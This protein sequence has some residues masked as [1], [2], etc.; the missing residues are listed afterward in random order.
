MEVIDNKVSSVLVGHNIRVVKHR[1]LSYPTIQ[2]KIFITAMLYR[3]LVS[4]TDLLHS[5]IDYLQSLCEFHKSYY[6]W[7]SIIFTFLD[8][9][10]VYVSSCKKGE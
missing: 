6:R 2:Q 8:H 3:Q 9:C 4:T 10:L 1:S 5:N 7:K